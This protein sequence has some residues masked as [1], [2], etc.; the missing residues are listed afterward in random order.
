MRRKD[1]EITDISMIEKIL[2]EAE[3]IRIAMVDGG[4]PYL[5]AMNYAYADGAIYMHSAKE[6]RKIDILKK[7]N[8]VAFQVDKDVELL[9]DKEACRCGTKY[10]SVFGTGS[11][12]FISDY[13]GKRAALDAIMTRY[14]GRSGFN[15]PNEVMDRTLVIKLEIDTITGKKSGY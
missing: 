10:L 7:N 15:Y 6:G 8:K 12:F 3:V 2:K 5:V 13:E 1:K 9:L 4:M 11:A 14:S